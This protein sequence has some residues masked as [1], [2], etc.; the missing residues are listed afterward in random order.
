MTI[1]IN[2]KKSRKLLFQELYAMSFNVFE[3]ESFKESFFDN[4]FSFTQDED[5]V[6]EMVKIITFY[7][8]FF[9]H[10][11]KMYTPKFK[12]ETMSLSTVLPI[13]IWLAEM[14]YLKEEIPG[15]VSINE[16]VEIA[17]VYG[18]DS[19]KKIVNG[20]LNKVFNNHDVLSKIKDDD[21]SSITESCFKK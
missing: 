10:I 11:L 3:L 12:I 19:S 2:R 18:D 20:V 5:Y 15:K 21:Y 7:E 8:N 16:A 14:F 17:K 9:I 1:K 13:Y 6:N 4:V